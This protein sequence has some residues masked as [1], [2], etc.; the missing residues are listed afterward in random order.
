MPERE[1][2]TR[3]TSEQRNEPVNKPERPK[4]EADGVL[5]DIVS[6]RPGRSLDVVA[7]ADQ[8]PYVEP[9]NRDPDFAS[10]PP[11]DEQLIPEAFGEAET[12]QY[13]RGQP[14]RPRDSPARELLQRLAQIWRALF[15][16]RRF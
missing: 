5:R 7:P 4:D 8:V 6:P 3:T 10:V 11:A 12:P 2:E 15:G 13:R 16:P 9:P 14:R 1:D